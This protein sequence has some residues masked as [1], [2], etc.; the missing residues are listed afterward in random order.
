MKERIKDIIGLLHL[1]IGIII[2][3]VDIEYLRW[4]IHS[5]WAFLI[6]LIGLYFIFI[7]FANLFWV[8]G[9]TNDKKHC[10]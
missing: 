6:C 10:T 3:L 2:C 9:I 1:P 7:G 8:L 4:M 5:Y